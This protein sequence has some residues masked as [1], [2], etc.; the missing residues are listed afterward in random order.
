MQK[1][2]IIFIA[3]FSVSLS[4]LG[5]EATLRLLVWEGYAPEKYIA[6]FEEEVFVKYGKKVKFKVTYVD[7]SD[8][9]YDPIRNKDVDLVTPSHQLFKDQRY[10]YISNKLLLPLDVKKIS[11]Y[12]NLIPSLQKAD[13]LSEDGEVYGIPVAQ[14]PYGL[15]YNTGKIKIPP[16]SWNIFWDPANKGRYVLAAQEYIYNAGITALA[17]G[18]PRKSIC[19]YDALNNDEFRKK[20]RELTV[21]AD[22]FW[23]GQDKAEDLVGKNI[24]TAWGDSINGLQ[25]RGET[26]KIAEPKEGTMFWID[27]YA[28]TWSLK[29]KPFLKKIAL[30]WISKTISKEFQLENITRKLSIFPTVTNISKQFT[31]QEKERIN[32]ENPDLV[33]ERR[34]PMPT[35]SRRDRNGIKFLWQEAMEG[36]LEKKKGE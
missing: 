8:D 24:A 35:L 21:N 15:A 9:F 17:L 1:W 25:G 12:K 30:E 16:R 31:A 22:S 28:K 32:M 2:I 6:E 7:G 26:W 13:F 19:S 34:I 36:L 10:K 23:L 18:Y 5:E 3:L 29:D 20:L 11:N 14:G 4:A 27:S 33:K